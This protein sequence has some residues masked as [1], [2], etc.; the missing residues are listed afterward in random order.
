MKLGLPAI[1]GGILAV[2]V[3]GAIVWHSGANPAPSYTGYHG[4]GVTTA[5]NS[6]D[7]NPDGS[8]P[9]Q[10][11]VSSNDKAYQDDSLDQQVQMQKDSG[12]PV[13]QNQPK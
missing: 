5:N 12:K 4:N 2:V 8:N 9:K 13:Q 1:I 3:I 7:S 11:I 6:S 10:K